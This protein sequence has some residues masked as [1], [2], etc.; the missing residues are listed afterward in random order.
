MPDV[1]AESCTAVGAVD[2]WCFLDRVGPLT[3]AEGT[4]MD[5]ASPC[6]TARRRL[7]QRVDHFLRF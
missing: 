1:A 3:F 6:S 4:P 2:P 7:M 5:V